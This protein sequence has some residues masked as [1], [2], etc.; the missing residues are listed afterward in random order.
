MCGSRQQP[1]GLVI[2]FIHES[3]P[4]AGAAQRGPRLMKALRA[5]L[6]GHPQ[7]DRMGVLDLRSAK[8]S[9]DCLGHLSLFLYIY[10]MPQTQSLSLS[11]QRIYESWALR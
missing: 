2:P 7:R 11:A 1:L 3:G 9:R 8:D 4:H 6:S 10:V 5:G